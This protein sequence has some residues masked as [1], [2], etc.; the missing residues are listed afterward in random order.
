MYAWMPGQT[1]ESIEKTA[2]LQAMKFYR[3]NK[4]QTALSLG[5]GLRTLDMKLEKYD[6]EQRD[7]AE[8]RAKAIAIRTE[9][10]RRA[11]G[12]PQENRST[13]ITAVDTTTRMAVEPTHAAPS[14]HQ[15]SVS[16]RKEVQEMLQKPARP[17][18]ARR[19]GGRASKVT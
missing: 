13:L 17:S 12:L 18:G 3:G 19:A 2:I 5:M 9:F 6:A 14:E 4:S 1:L 11:K 8:Q 10:L 15:V 7:S 16:E